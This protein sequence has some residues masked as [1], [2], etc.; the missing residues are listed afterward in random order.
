MIDDLDLEKLRRVRRISYYFRYPLHRG[1]F[2]ELK[3]RKR[4]QGHYT[5]KPLYGKLMQSGHVD[6]SA[7]YNGD[8][9]ALYVPFEARCV[10]DA[11]LL[12]THIEPADVALPSGQRNW[13]NILAAAESMILDAIVSLDAGERERQREIQTLQRSV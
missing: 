8:I 12:V 11:N 6:R 3:V 9:A 1:D 7:G 10:D 5:A 2:H 13:P 4:L